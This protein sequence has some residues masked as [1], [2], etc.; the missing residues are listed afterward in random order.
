MLAS[1]MHLLAE[2]INVSHLEPGDAGWGDVIFVSL[3]AICSLALASYYCYK[4]FFSR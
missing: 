3:W 2:N 1:T 4:A